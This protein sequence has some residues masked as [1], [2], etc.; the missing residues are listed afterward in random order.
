LF[1]GKFPPRRVYATT[2]AADPTIFGGTGAK[3]AF[4]VESFAN[5]VA[6]QLFEAW[7]TSHRHGP[8]EHWPRPAIAIAASLEN[9]K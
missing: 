7:M 6:I 2:P 4:F 5:T 3:A 1:I 8:E 9:V